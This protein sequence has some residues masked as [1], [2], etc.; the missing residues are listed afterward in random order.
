[1]A[2]SR[3]PDSD[4][5]LVQEPEPSTSVSS[6]SRKA[7]RPDHVENLRSA[8]QG[9]RT[10]DATS[11]FE[12]LLD[13]GG[14]PPPVYPMSTPLLFA[15]QPFGAAAD[16]SGRAL[17]DQSVVAAASL[18]VRQCECRRGDPSVS[19]SWPGG[20][21]DSPATL[22]ST[23]DIGGT[24]G[25]SAGRT[26]GK[27]LRP[28]LDYTNISRQLKPKDM[29]PIPWLVAMALQ[30]D[31][32]WL[33]SDIIWS[34]PNAMPQSVRDRPTLSHE[35]LF[36]LT[37]A[38]DYYYDAEAIKEPSVTGDLRRPYTSVG[39][40]QL[41]GRPDHQHHGGEVRDSD[42]SARNRRSVWTIPTQPYEGAHFATF[43]EKLVEPCIMAGTSEKGCC[44]ECGTPWERIMEKQRGPAPESW[45]QSAFDDGRNA[46]VHP[47]V[48]KRTTFNIR[49][50]DAKR[51]VATAQEGYR[52]SQEEIANYG[53]EQIAAY[54]TVGWEPTCACG[55]EDT[56]PCL[57]LD[58][59]AGSGTVPVVA[60]KLGRHAVGLDL[61]EAYLKLAVRRLE[62]VNL[63]LRETKR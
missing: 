36:L 16:L 61:S 45:H 50:R 31:G 46:E 33:R 20:G 56:Q 35:Y 12:P 15:E 4:V 43:P 17:G 52:A 29:V 51:G 48:G 22:N 62:G 26:S 53:E 13:L 24:G 58:P 55:R 39:A 10:T 40:W 9:A 19:R 5:D 63:P 14:A 27:A 59:F 42:P 18:G 34:K 2:E 23:D 57:V 3:T 6:R 32:W 60:Q 1:M 28:Y 8:S 38:A 25:A 37:K 30:A 11:D 47:N 44:P 21:Q 49:V 7:Q 54:Q 41:D